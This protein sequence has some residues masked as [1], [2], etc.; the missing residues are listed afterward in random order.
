M[1]GCAGACS[2]VGV[3]GGETGEGSDDALDELLARPLL[4]QPAATDDDDVIDVP[5]DVLDEE[6]RDPHREPESRR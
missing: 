5:E 4:A 3:G 2:A 1:I 6:H